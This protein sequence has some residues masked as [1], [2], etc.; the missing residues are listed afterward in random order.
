VGEQD[1]T[2]LVLHAGTLATEGRLEEAIDTQR[3]AIVLEPLAASYH[4]NL[5]HMLLAAGDTAE[6]EAEFEKAL[7]ISGRSG[8]ELA[9]DF[10]AARILRSEFEEALALVP[11]MKAVEDRLAVRAMTAH[12]KGRTATADRLSNELAALGGAWAIVRL[13]E[14]RSFRGDSEAVFDALDRLGS[15]LEARDGERW[16]SGQPL[17]ELRLSPFLG[18][19]HAEPTLIERFDEVLDSYYTSE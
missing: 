1:P 10:A 16:D 13:A 12:G 8:S 14:V 19:L 4:Y 7:S 3:R 9:Y 2:A 5:G 6:A 18:K 17:F 15:I 11:E